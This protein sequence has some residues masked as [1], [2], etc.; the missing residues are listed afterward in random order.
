MNINLKAKELF[1]QGKSLASDKLFEEAI[2]SYEDA[3]K[4]APEWPE[5]LY[6][7]AFIY[8]IQ[9]KFDRALEFYHKVDAL[10]PGGYFTTKVAIWGLEM[11]VQKKYPEGLYVAFAQVDWTKNKTRRLE[12]LEEIVE[13]FPDYAPAWRKLSDELELPEDRMIAI[14]RGLECE[15]L[16]IESSGGLLI[17]KALV[18]QMLGDKQGAKQQLKALKQTSMSDNNRETVEFILSTMND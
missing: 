2:F 13:K 1:A 11:E 12:I 3:A 4:L 16:D 17:N 5:P 10:R 6:E 15:D 7:I 14:N 8:L 9:T 18:T